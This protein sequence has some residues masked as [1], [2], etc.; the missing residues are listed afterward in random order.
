MGPASPTHAVGGC[1]GLAGRQTSQTEVAHAGTNEG[2]SK[3]SVR[4]A[5]LRAELR[6]ETWQTAHDAANAYLS[7]KHEVAKQAANELSLKDVD[8]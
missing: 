1:T 8:K 2:R 6:V 4:H 7:M 3:K 5:R